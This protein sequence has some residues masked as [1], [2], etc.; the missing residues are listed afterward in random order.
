MFDIV[1]VLDA[2]DGV[3]PFATVN[4]KLNSKKES[5]RRQAALELKEAARKFYVALSRAKKRLCV[6]YTGHL[7]PF[8]LHIRHHFT[9]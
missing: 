4:S 2:Y 1:V 7:T 5:E 3:Y 6:S 8:M 9:S